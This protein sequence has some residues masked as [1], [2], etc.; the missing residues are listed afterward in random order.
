MHVSADCRLKLSR[1]PF[2][3]YICNITMMCIPKPCLFDESFTQLKLDQDRDLL[4]YHLD[5]VTFFSEEEAFTITL[6][7]TGQA[8]YHLLGSFSPSALM[9]LICYSTLYYPLINFNERLMA[10]ITSLLVL[11]ALFSQATAT[12]VKTPYFKLLDVWY[13]VLIGLC[14]LIVFANSLIHMLQ[15][16]CEDAQMV[17]TEEDDAEANGGS[18]TKRYVSKRASWCNI[19]FRYLLLA[20]FILLIIT[21]G[22]LERGFV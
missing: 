3:R 19:T 7:L 16:R 8:D 2:G 21:Y 10:S 22:L 18:K 20:I 4:D 6:H 14:F 9:F 12:N 17:A 13:V 1:Y 5:N 11:V 15:E